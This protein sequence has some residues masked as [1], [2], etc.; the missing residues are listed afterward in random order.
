MVEDPKPI[1]RH[2]SGPE[3]EQKRSILQR[4]QSLLSKLRGWYTADSGDRKVYEFDESGQLV[5]SLL[6]IYVEGRYE[7]F[8]IEGRKEEVSE[9]EGEDFMEVD[10]LFSELL[11]AEEEWVRLQKVREG[12]KKNNPDGIE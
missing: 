2:Q 1:R 9:V 11:N 6:I 12:Y 3:K 10:E 8:L 5:S 4:W 7:T